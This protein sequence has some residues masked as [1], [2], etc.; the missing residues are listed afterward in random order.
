M[1]EVDAP[2]GLSAALVV[3]DVSDEQRERRSATG[4]LVSA[5]RRLM[6]HV[7]TSQAS[8]EVLRGAARAVDRVVAD[9]GPPGP[10]MLRVPFDAAAVDRVRDGAA[11]P[12]F[13]FNPMAAPLQIRIEGRRAWGELTPGALYEGPPG[14]LH[15]GFS[16]HLLDAL[17]GTL[18]QAQG[19]PGYTA[20]LDL[21]FH[22]PTL[23]DRRTLVEGEMGEAEGRKMRATGWISQDGRRTVEARGLFVGPSEGPSDAIR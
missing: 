16:A 22:A 12:M 19:T 5:T 11:W 4:A 6:G 7:S 14:F 1:G 9:L 10:R 13:V 20:Q 8:P 21:R 18:V 3:E 17:L 15:G 2:I 23:L